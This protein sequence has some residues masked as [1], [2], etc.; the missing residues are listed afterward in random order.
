MK[1]WN[2]FRWISVWG[3]N[4]IYFPIFI[5]KDGR[6]AVEQ[7]AE[8]MGKSFSADVIDKI[9]AATTFDAM[10]KNKNVNPDVFIPAMQTLA[11]AIDTSN[12]KSFFRKG[13]CFV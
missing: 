9:V 13:M 2:F 10:K 7:I 12:N 8:F 6:K 5:F 4:L 1:K 3:S 11:L